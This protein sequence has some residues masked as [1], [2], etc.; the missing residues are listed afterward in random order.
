MS[1]VLVI[2]YG[3]LLRGDDGVGRLAAGQLAERAD[4]PDVEV[5]AAHQVTVEMSEA[6]SRAEYVLF[7]DAAAEGVPGTVRLEDLDPDAAP[8]APLSHHVD[9]SAVL[10]LANELFGRA[11]TACRLTLTGAEFG[12]GEQLSAPVSAAFPQLLAVARDKIDAWRREGD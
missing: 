6:V 4:F 7:V 9:A 5:I 11:P 2:G 8:A 3:N 12:Y 1:R 10:R